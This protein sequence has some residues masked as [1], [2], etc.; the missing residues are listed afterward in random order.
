MPTRSLLQQFL[1]ADEGLSQEEEE[2]TTTCKGII[3]DQEERTVGNS[4]LNAEGYD[5]KRALLPG[6]GIH[7]QTVVPV[8]R[9]HQIRGMCERQD[10]GTLL[11]IGVDDDEA[12]PG[13]VAQRGLVA[14]S[15]TFWAVVSPP[16]PGPPAS[17]SSRRAQGSAVTDEGATDSPP[18]PSPPRPL[19]GGPTR[20]EVALCSAPGPIRGPPLRGPPSQDDTA[21]PVADGL[22]VRKPS[23][24]R[25]HS[26]PPCQRRSAARLTGREGQRGRNR[27]PRGQGRGGLAAGAGGGASGEARAPASPAQPHRPPP[28]PRSTPRAVRTAPERPARPACGLGPR[29]GGSPSKP[30]RRRRPQCGAALS[31]APSQRRPGAERGAGAA[32]AGPA[33]GP[34]ARSPA[35]GAAGSGRGGGSVDGGPRVSPAL[36]PAGQRGDRPGQPEERPPPPPRARTEKREKGAETHGNL[37]PPRKQCREQSASFGPE[38]PAQRGSQTKGRLITWTFFQSRWRQ[39]S[40]GADALNLDL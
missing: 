12:G 33:S 4:L 6:P 34:P 3:D 40:P 31:S 26:A 5:Q 36:R 32:E 22:P 35:G 15:G 21:Q 28:P 38:V 14:S 30:Q 16:G 20:S 7:L 9:R 2:D 1:R 37:I 18:S 23:P 8:L 11:E 25:L 29:R 39:R 19:Q 17:P 10:T 27:Q 24:G 13:L